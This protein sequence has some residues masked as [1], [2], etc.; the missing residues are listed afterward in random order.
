MKKQANISFLAWTA[1]LARAAGARAVL[2]LLLLLVTSATARG[3][4][5]KSESPIGWLD[6]AEGYSLYI[7]VWGWSCDPYYEAGDIL[8]GIDLVSFYIS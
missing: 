6:G 1:R 2:V 8:S 7:H 3:G 5:Q 4:S